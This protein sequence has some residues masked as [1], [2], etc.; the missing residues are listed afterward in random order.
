MSRA[1]ELLARARRWW[2]NATLL[3]ITHDV[4]ETRDFERV[5]VI[6]DG[7]VVEDD[8][9]SVL[10]RTP[11]SRYGAMLVAELE[12]RT[13]MWASADWRRLHLR[14]GILEER[15]DRASSE[16]AVESETSS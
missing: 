14:D 13:G 7:R 8:A 16:R 1:S 3:C 2:K 9:P 6:E 4:G 5:I 12:V 10:A 11:D 15:I